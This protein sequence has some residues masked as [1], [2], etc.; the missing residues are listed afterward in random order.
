MFCFPLVNNNKRGLKWR[1]EGV[2]WLVCW[3]QCRPGWTNMAC[4]PKI[5]QHH[6]L[7]YVNKTSLVT[8]PVTKSSLVAKR[9]PVTKLHRWLR[10]WPNFTGDQ[11]PPVAKAHRWPKYTGDQKITGYQRITDDQSTPVTTLHRC[12]NFTGDQKVTGEQAYHDS[13]VLAYLHVSR[14]QSHWRSL[15]I[16]Y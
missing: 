12:P 10:R 13:T 11:R 7:R 8:S 6:W 9:S 1:S 16:K 4:F 2:C 14:R 5:Q 15:G 3:L